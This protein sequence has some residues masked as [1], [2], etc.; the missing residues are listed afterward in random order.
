MWR[1]GWRMSGMPFGL[2]IRDEL[3]F[4]APLRSESLSAAQRGRGWGPLRSNGRVR[5]CSMR[6]WRVD[7]GVEEPTSPSP[8]DARVPSLSPRARRGRRGP[9]DQADNNMK[10]TIIGGGIGG[11]SAALQLLKA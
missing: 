7:H 8:R 2:Q 11:L 6:R 4:R 9:F 3:H 10:I 5:W 1:G